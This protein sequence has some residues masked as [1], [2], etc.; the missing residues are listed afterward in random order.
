MSERTIHLLRMTNYSIK[1]LIVA[2]VSITFFGCS[3]YSKLEV[4]QKQYIKSTDKSSVI[5][6]KVKRIRNGWLPQLLPSELQMG[7]TLYLIES[8]DQALVVY[9]VNYWIN[10]ENIRSFS[11]NNFS[12]YQLENNLA[13][14][15]C[16]YNF[17][18]DINVSLSKDKIDK[19]QIWGDPSI[20]IASRVFLNN[21]NKYEYDF[22]YFLEFVCDDVWEDFQNI[23]K[24]S[25][26]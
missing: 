24:K 7:D 2:F 15:T 4:E 6:N 19:K 3:F 25:G 23:K 1:Y 16:Y 18:K 9:F 12:T 14:D 17:I 21:K 20:I 26:E 10:E 22:S 11:K 8:Y 5:Y 13:F